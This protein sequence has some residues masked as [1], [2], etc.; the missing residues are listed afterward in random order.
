MKLGHEVEVIAPERFK[1]VP[2]PTYPEIRLA[3]CTPAR[4]GSIIA[5]FAPEAVHIATEG[6]LGWSARWWLKRRGIP[7]TT[8]FHTMFPQYLQMRIGIP[9]AWSFAGLRRF[10]NAAGGTM[11]STPRLRDML[12]DQGFENLLGWVRGVDTEIFTPGEAQPLDFPRPI[13]MYVGRVAVEKGIEDFLRTDTPGTK[14]IV[15]DGPQRA[16]LERRYPDVVFLGP[17]YGEEL[18]RHYRAA[19]VFVFPSRTD[20]LGLVMLE[21]MACGVPVAAFPVQGPLDVVADS[22]AGVLDE[23]LATAVAGALSI[24]PEVCRAR[25]LE[26]S[27]DQSVTEFHA[28][29][30]RIPA[31]SY[32]SRKAPINSPVKG[33]GETA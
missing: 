9:T 31:D 1:N 3:M 15:G 16:A 29:L 5:D 7:F 2:C 17:K 11:Y 30:I 20:T 12:R 14:V 6:P 23:N 8:S 19:D 32:Q 21:A 26:H 4:V 18:V 13:A 10:H 24:H 25:A 33:E 28:N 27:W 22:G